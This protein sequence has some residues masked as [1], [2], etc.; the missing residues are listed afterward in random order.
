MFFVLSSGRSGSYTISQT[1]NSYENCKCYHQRDPQFRV[2]ASEYYYGKCLGDKIEEVLRVTRSQYAEKV[3]AYGEVNLQ[4]GLIVPVI[5]R[6]F[7]DAKY[8][9][10]LRDGRDV[11][12][13][14][15]Y[16]RWYDL[17]DK[18]VPD[19][20]KNARLQG[21]LTGDFSTSEW[22]NMSRFA[23]CCWLWKKYNHI[24]ESHLQQF[25]KKRWMRV[26]LDRLKALLSDI[27]IFLGLVSD[28]KV[29]VEKLNTAYQPVSYW[30]EWDD[31]KK[32]IFETICSNE[33]DEWFPEWKNKSGEWSKID[34]D[35]PD[36]P[37]LFVLLKR[38]PQRVRIRAWEVKRNMLR[39]CR[40]SMNNKRGDKA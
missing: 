1:L 8:I 10:L 5:E 37:G 33:M 35:V 38:V 30:E 34:P 29:L 21:D 14:M 27:E 31:E 12:A 32:N 6:V 4:F 36:K 40:G 9:W 15:Y 20:W 17:T 26:R 7:P 19:E 39:A 16:R 13:S 18:K 2:E 3:E 11:V 25:D 22:R 28:K 23:K 24:I